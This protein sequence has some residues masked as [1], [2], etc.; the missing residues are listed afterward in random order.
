MPVAQRGS[1]RRPRILL[2]NSH[3]GIGGAE[4]VTAAL[5][6]G[7]DRVRFDVTVAYIKWRGMIGDALVRDGFEVVGLGNG[8]GERPDYLSSLRLRRFLVARGFDL[9]HTND[10]H[11]M[12][13]AAVCRTTLR[14]LRLVS[15]FHFGNY[16][17]PVRRYHLLEK[18]VSRVPDRLVAVGQWQADRLCDVYGF[19]P[20]R[21]DLIRNGVPDVPGRRSQD[22]AGRIRK[23][24]RVV[25]GSVSTLIE[26]KGVTDLLD[27]A[28][29]LRTQGLD[30]RL[31]IAGEGHLRPGLEEKARALG[32]QDQVEFFG[33]V[34]DAP[35]RVLPWVDVFVQTSLWEAMSMVV[36]EAMSCA[37]PIV[38]TRVGENPHVIHHGVNG[39]L[40]EPRDV[41]A[42]TEH[43]AGLIRSGD[44]RRRLGEKARQD[45]ETAYTA[46][47]MCRQ[48]E[49]LYART[50][51]Q[52]SGKVLERH[53]A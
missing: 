30:F 32:L 1:Q 3:L 14:R 45:W 53:A 22:I 17:R 39:L 37:L 33:W 35:A 49:D 26:Q 7:L 28:A 41:A 47:R 27:V 20:E 2:L 24:G 10:I 42:L 15:T 19:Q 46:A 43:L 12:I 25:I 13:D 18:Y 4:N 29:N 50:L 48:Y 40:A 21:L 8:D 11:A 36:L 16:P 5:C 38:A 34:D 9:V 6:R 44:L 23:D 51:A 31:V 52:R